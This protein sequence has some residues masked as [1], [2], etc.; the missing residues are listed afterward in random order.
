M[1]YIYPQILTTSLN[2]ISHDL[3]KDIDKL[4]LFNLKEKYENICTENGFIVKDSIKLINRNIGK[5]IT[6]NNKSY[7]N[8]IVRYSADII[9][10][11][12]GDELE[13]IV[14]RVNKMGVLGYISTKQ[15]DFESSPVIIIVPNEYF[16]ES[17]RDINS[18]TK[19]QKMN[20]TIIGSRVKYGNKKIQIVAK[21]K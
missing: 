10:L 12:E 13:I 11:N 7:I 5:I 15:N 4:I 9:N 3:N 17:T 20:V 6:I 21:P 16:T 8:Y 19:N 2:I 1:S 14:D 18:L